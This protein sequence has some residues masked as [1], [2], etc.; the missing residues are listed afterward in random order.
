MAP[1]ALRIPISWVRSVTDT[2]MMFITPTPP[3]KS[4]IPVTAMPIISTTPM[5]LLKASSS[6]SILLMAKFVLVARME[7]A[8]LAHLAGQ[9]VLEVL[10]VGPRR[11]LDGECEAPVAPAEVPDEGRHRDEDLAV[12]VRAA[13]EPGAALFLHHADHPEIGSADLDLLVDRVDVAEELLAHGDADDAD[14]AFERHIGGG[15]E[16]AELGHRARHQHVLVGGADDG[17]VVDHL[18]A[19]T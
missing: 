7:P 18:R 16:T 6:E 2:N 5:T 14:V 19:G 13:E 1:I 10:D 9:V 11:R 8:D 15:E 3:T 17:R 12:E 4:E